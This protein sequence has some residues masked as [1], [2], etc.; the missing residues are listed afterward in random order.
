MRVQLRTTLAGLALWILAGSSL[1]GTLDVQ[2]ALEGQVAVSLG[3]VSTPGSTTGTAHVVLAGVDSFGAITGPSASATLRS[4]TLQTTLSSVGPFQFFQLEP[5]TGPFDGASFGIT[6]MGVTFR[7]VNG[8][9]GAMADFTNQIAFAVQLA[10]LGTP[11][12]GQLTF[13]G[14]LGAGSIAVQF[15]LV[16]R[17]VSRS[18]ST[19]E[20]YEIGLVAMGLALI[21]AVSAWRTRA[22]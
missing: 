8:I 14:A 9:S 2:F 3:F 20:P 18:F 13:N 17:E 7:G 12:A 5:V 1:A 21:A 6:P 4:L 22:E 10:S 19:P 16:G 11:G 15:D